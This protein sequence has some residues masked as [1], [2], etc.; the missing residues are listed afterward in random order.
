MDG[1]LSNRRKLQVLINVVSY[2]TYQNDAD[3]Y[4]DDY[5][6][7]DILNKNILPVVIRADYNRDEVESEMHHPYSHITS[8]GYKNCRIPVD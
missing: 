1:Y 3:L 7:G 8:G 5:I 2:E 6:Y 4:D